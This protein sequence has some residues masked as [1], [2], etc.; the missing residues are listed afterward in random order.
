MRKSFIALSVVIG[1]V[2]LIAGLN[3]TSATLPVRSE[4]AKDPRNK[5][6]AMVAYLGHFVDPATLVVD[7]RGIS[8]EVSQADVTRG[9]FQTA[10]A[11]KE[12]EFKR[13]ILAHRGTAK[14]QMEGAFFRSLGQDFD[15]G[16]NPVYLTRTLPEHVARL[17]G[18][19]A[20]ETWT[21][22]LFGVV[23]KQME[24]F[25]DL[26]KAWWLNDELQRISN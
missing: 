22:G 18:T 8:G 12:K 11:L 9:L 2:A 17:D 16:Q 25:G 10:V 13:V 26:H 3:L 20:F 5:T 19:P 6:V 15:S 24:D 1:V 14:F 4:L 21:G 7:I 23:A